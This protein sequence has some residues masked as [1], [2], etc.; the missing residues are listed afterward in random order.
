MCEVVAT[1]VG[2]GEAALGGWGE[3]VRGEGEKV[4]EA[5]GG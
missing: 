4:A 5:W 1:A 3:A 2:L